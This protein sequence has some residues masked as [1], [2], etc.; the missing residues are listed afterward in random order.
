MPVVQD[1]NRD[2]ETEERT[3][4]L[5]QSALL[6][7]VT[8]P[9]APKAHVLLRM[10]GS[11]VGQ[12]YS[13]QSQQ[14]TIG[15]LASNG[16]CVDQEGISRR[17]ARL[18][19]IDGAYHLEDLNSANGTFVGAERVKRHVLRHGDLIQLGPRVVYRYSIT[20]SQEEQMLRQLYEA[21]VRDSL[22]GAYNRDYLNERLKAEVAYARR[23]GT[24]LSLIL[25]DLDYFKRINDEHGHPAGDAVLV[26]TV[27]S[28]SSA[29]RTEDLFAR[30]GGEEFAVM[31]RGIDL[32]GTARAGERMRE[33]VEKTLIQLAHSSVSCTVSAGCASL[34]CCETPSVEGLLGTAD[35]RLY[36]AKHAGRNRVVAA[37]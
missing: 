24:H 2:D 4:V 12:V 37:G 3:T 17:H 20:D 29:L 35:R 7:G 13:L 14:L 22:T 34:A 19:F 10:D 15:R 30:Y 25:L 27:A 23:H 16:L 28:L 9:I 5:D 18:A 36:A 6:E 31:L 33:T 1:D 26:A 32:E 8:K 11:N 21:S